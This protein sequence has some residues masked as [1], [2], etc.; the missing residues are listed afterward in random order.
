MKILAPKLKALYLAHKI[1]STAKQV[2]HWEKQNPPETWAPLPEG[3]QD[4]M[5]ILARG[6][7]IIR[8]DLSALL[9]SLP[10]PEEK[11]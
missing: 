11:I 4:P 9:D 6:E 2:E 8:A 1:P 3:L 10:K 5:A 7:V